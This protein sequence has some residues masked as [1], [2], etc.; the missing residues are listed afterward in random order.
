MGSWTLTKSA[1]V[2]LTGALLLTACG[3]DSGV[4]A[5][6]P[7][8]PPSP[9]AAPIPIGSPPSSA[10]T[11]PAATPPASASAAP[12]DDS[13]AILAQYRA[14]F[15]SLTPLSMTEPVARAAAMKRLA[16][17]PALARVLGGMASSEQVGEVGYGTPVLRPKIDKIEGDTATILDCQDTSGN[18]RLA[19]AT[20]K[21]VTV[22]RKNDYAQVTVQR[23]PDGV[24]RVATVA[25]A[26]AGSCNAEA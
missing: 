25:Y 14:F 8:T 2:V 16:V 3:G 19:K 22:G 24:W 18:G 13:A 23:G 7:A 12:A 15:D 20:G 6:G 5:Q 4:D 26:A 1:G 10:T 9:S 21:V 11:S 17:D